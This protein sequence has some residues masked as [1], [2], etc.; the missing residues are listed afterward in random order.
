MK[1][2]CLA[3]LIIISIFI[4]F[5]HGLSNAQVDYPTKPIQVLVG[6]P[7]GG[8]TDILIRALA[9]EAKKYLGK[10][11]VII[12]KPGAAGTVGGI[13]VAIANP[14]G[15]TLGA[16][17]STA[18]TISPFLMDVSVDLV[19]QTTPIL[20]FAKFYGGMFARAD[21]PFKNLKDFLDYA[22]KNPD[23]ATYGHPG[24]ATRPY[25]GMAMIAAHE[26]VKINFVAFPGDAPNA[27][28]L[29]GGHILSAGGSAGTVWISQIQAGQLKFLA[30]EERLY[31]FPEVPT[32]TELGY[33]Y[34]LPTVV[35]LFGPKNLPEPIV[36]KLEDAFYKA[37]QS[38]AFK[39]LAMK[40]VV[41]AEKNMFREELA[42]FLHTE[43]AKTGELIKKFG[44]G[45]K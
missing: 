35:F 38:T 26:G 24:A 5:S 7:P 44:F 33:P 39:D 42:T 19:T 23:K 40:N 9:E 41:Y 20:S 28:A 15:Y 31:M 37:M 43:K 18:F 4:T 8:S 29:L 34:S 11:V 27:A 32:V 25:L 12:N 2:N 14:D 16:I 6:Y 30:V 3:P 21:S 36:K 10:E 45:K 13:Q 1:A 22:K 17:V